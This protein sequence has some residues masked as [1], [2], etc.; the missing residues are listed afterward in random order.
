MAAA[1]GAG[2]PVGEPTGSMVVDIGGGTSEVAVISL[3]GIV[4]SQSIR[5]GGDELDEAIINYAKREYKLLI[6]QQTAEE[7]KLEIGSAYPMEEEVQAEIR[8]RD[9]V[10]GL[11][12]TVVLTSEEIRQAL[13]EPLA[14]I[15]DAVK[16]TL[17]RT[18]PE[19]ASDIMDRGIMLAGGGAL[20]QGLDE[21]LREET[22]MPAHLAE[23]PL[24]CVAVGSG[25]SLEEF[26]VDPPHATKTRG[27]PARAAASSGTAARRH[28]HGRG[29]HVYD[30]KTVRRRRAVLGLLVACSLILL[31]AYFGE[32]RRRAA[33]DA[34]GLPEVLSP[35]EE[36]AQRRAQ[37]GA[38]L[39]PAG[40]ATRSHA[41][42][43]NATAAQGARRLRA[44]GHRPTGAS[45]SNDVAAKLVALDQT[46]GARRRRSRSPR[47]SIARSPTLW[48]STVNIDKGASDG[49]ARQRRR[50]INGDGLVGQRHG[51]RR[52][53]GAKVTLITDRESGVS[54]RRR[55]RGVD[56]HRRDRRAGRPQRPAD[57]LR[58]RATTR[59]ARATRRNG[60]HRVVDG[61]ES[62]LPAGHPDRRRSRRPTPTSSRPPSRS[63][64]RPIANLR[65]L[66][67][68]QVL[69]AATG[70]AAR[71]ELTP[72]P[73]RSCVSARS[74]LVAVVRPG[75]GRLAGRRCFGATA[76]LSPL[77]VAAVGL[78]CGLARRRR[79]GFAVGLFVDVALLQ[80]M[81]LTSL[82]L[83]AVG[84]GAG[85]LRELRD[86][87]SAL[88]PLVVGAARRGDRD[89]GYGVVQ[90][91]LGVD[92]PVSWLLRQARS[93]RRSSL[94]ALL[95][96]PVYA[97]VR[98]WLAPAL[99]EDPR[100]RRRRAYTTGGLSPLHTAHERPLLHPP[101]TAG[102]RSRRS[103]RCASRSSAC[104]AL[105]LFAIIFFRLWFLQVLAGDKYLAR[106]TRTASATSRSP[107]PRGEIVD[108]NGTPIVD[109]R[110]AQRRADRPASLPPAS[111]TRGD[112]GQDA[113][114]AEA[115]ARCDARAR[116]A[117][118]R[119]DRG[120][121]RRSRRIGA[122]R[123]ARS[124]RCSTAP[125]TIQSA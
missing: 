40:S 83:L 46:A 25:R 112:W 104:I 90:F 116:H 66:D 113:R 125:T 52:R 48:Y 96:L 80:T 64:S 49:V 30:R 87:Q 101:R 15:I 14:Q 54:A 63:T 122:E 81:G 62:L 108:R 70:R 19:L 3:G 82:V 99:P 78:L 102:R 45:P 61:L 11:P 53:R 124:A 98:R 65:D 26:E 111:V 86:P 77:V 28:P 6:G 43:D 5:V 106:P 100:R 9:M 84:Y 69:T 91:L 59:S 58:C 50:S 35:I 37:A 114:A 68:V 95:A 120:R 18:P 118:A 103:S 12:K 57:R 8:G 16:E 119:A 73:R 123:F 51:G 23:R 36:G 107:A 42:K 27:T 85:R 94:D 29:L 89:V 97:L 67:I 24:T 31:T 22:Q 93:S 71:W 117:A 60:R 121:C 105:A 92:A 56:R 39:R 34:A 1:I 4:V 74:A 75:R 38:R 47:A 20:L 33:L 32:S 10:S 115:D 110:L 76:D 88:T 7:L 21:R 72:R 44:R 13:E 2:L 55:R 79:I 17:D 109:N 41:K